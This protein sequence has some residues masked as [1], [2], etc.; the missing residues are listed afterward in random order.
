MILFSMML[1]RILVRM[2]VCVCVRDRS[3]TKKISV[4]ISG[5]YR[6][7]GLCVK[8]WGCGNGWGILLW[9]YCFRKP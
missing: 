2:C 8:H 9:G 1:G 3:G 5:S 6:S 4:V 7:L